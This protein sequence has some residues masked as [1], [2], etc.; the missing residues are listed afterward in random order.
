[1]EIR[2]DTAQKDAL[3]AFHV[4]G[5]F[6]TYFGLDGGLNDF[7]I[8]GWSLGANKYRVWSEYNDG[9]GSGLDADLLDGQQSAYYT[10]I[11]GRLGYTP[12]NA[13]GGVVSGTVTVGNSTV[14]SSVNS[15]SIT[16]PKIVFSSGNTITDYHVSTS[17]PSGGSDGDIWIKIPT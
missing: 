15:T 7:V 12:F 13:A 10:D 8:G 9:A 6:A 2:Q 5:D 11:A 17:D 16:A 3:M 1:L 4:I 14:N